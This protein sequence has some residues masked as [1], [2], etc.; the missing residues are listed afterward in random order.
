MGIEVLPLDKD[1]NK[2]PTQ[3]DGKSQLEIVGQAKFTAVRGKI[4]FIFE[5]Y[6]ARVLHAEIL[7]GGPFMETNKLVQELHKKRIVVDGKHVFLENSPFCPNLTSE[8]SIKHL[9]DNNDDNFRTA[10]KA[11]EESANKKEEIKPDLYLI[12]MGPAV[13]KEIREK[14]HSIHKANETVFDGS[15]AGGYNG[16]SGDF[17]VNF[18]FSGGVP[19]TPDYHSTPPYNLSKD[20]ILMQAKIDNLE[21]Q[22]VVIKIADTKIIPKYAAPYMLALKNSA[23]NLPPGEYEKLSVKEKLKYN[24]FILCHNKL[25][26]HVEKKPAKVNTIDETTRIVGG[27]EYIITS[28]LTDSFWQRHIAEEKLPYMCFH[29][30]YRGTYIFLRS[31]QGL[32]NQSEGLEEMLSVVLQDCIMSGWCRILADNVYVMGHSHKETVDRWQIVLKLM[33]ANNLKLSPHKTACFPEKLDLLGW[34][35]QGKVLVPDPHRQNRLAVATLP[36]TVEQLRSYLGGYRTFY[37]CKENMSMILRDLELFVAGKK[38]SEKLEWTEQLKEKF[39]ES[40]TKIKDLDELYLPKPDDQLVVTSD[41][42][43]KGI[44]AT[45]WAMPEEDNTPKVVARFSAK[46]SRSMEKLYETEIKPKTLPCDGEMGAQFVAVKSPTFSSHIRASNKRTVSLVD[47][48]PVVQAASLLKNGKFSSSR[49]INNLMTAI[50]EHNLEFQHVSGKLGQNFADD[51]SS[52]NPASCDGGS[53]C[54]IC[55]FIEDCKTLTVGALSFAFTQEAIVGQ[56]AQAETNLVHEV[57]TG[58]KTIPFN[59][60]KAM[61]YLQDKD[62]DLLKVREYLTQ[63]CYFFKREPFY[64]KTG[65]KRA[66]FQQKNGRK[67][68]EIINFHEKNGRFLLFLKPH[69]VTLQGYFKHF[70]TPLNR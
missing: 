34:T 57:L 60:R 13:P 5:G 37:R 29:S 46:L 21:E 17:D 33:A 41:W 16:A 58:V 56:I 32:I 44:S 61:R 66:L 59:N 67:T 8:V 50:S 9:A 49:V 47:N 3:A 38:S 27:F 14:L 42:C 55:G 62:E 22:G 18:N 65:E 24:R 45:L 25:S 6:V 28:D 4:K 10:E 1:D 40:K 12:E 51:F 30:P 68:G 39:E 19:P 23:K 11:N 20:D 53:H 31:T 2:V 54:K 36:A 69:S 70:W 26:E 7:C 48:K 63:C 35:K 15:L 43:E 64:K 52:R